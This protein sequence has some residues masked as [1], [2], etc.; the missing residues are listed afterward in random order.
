MNFS[1][2]EVEGFIFDFDGVLTDNKVY[3][4]Q[5]GVESVAC[6]RADGLGFDVLK[7]INKKNKSLANQMLYESEKQDEDSGTLLDENNIL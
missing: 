7:K 3:L 1:F 6:S 4:N 2:E 5:Y